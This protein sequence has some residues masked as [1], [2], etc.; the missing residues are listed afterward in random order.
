MCVAFLSVFQLLAR[1]SY[2]ESL[3]QIGCVAP[4]L[5]MCLSLGDGMNPDEGIMVHPIG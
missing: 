4:R 3:V 2:L 5:L 1:Q